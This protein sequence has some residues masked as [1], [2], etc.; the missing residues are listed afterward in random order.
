MAEKH[1]E[2]GPLSIPK[3]ALTLMMLVYLKSVNLN[4]HGA[5]RVQHY[6]PHLSY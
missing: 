2:I 4:A 3:S 6:V 1:P 5:L